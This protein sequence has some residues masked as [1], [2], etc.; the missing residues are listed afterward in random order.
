MCLRGLHVRFAYRAARLFDREIMALAAGSDGPRL[1][2]L[3]CVVL[4]FSTQAEASSEPIDPF[5]LRF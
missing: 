3:I 5:W 2:R 4:I 1:I